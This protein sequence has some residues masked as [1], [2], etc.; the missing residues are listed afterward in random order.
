MPAGG[1]GRAS[2]GSGGRGDQSDRTR[3]LRD[4]QTM[5][6]NLDF[7]ENKPLCCMAMWSTLIPQLV[8]L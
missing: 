1:A 3:S 5:T 7:I 8:E 6:R 2:G 4:L